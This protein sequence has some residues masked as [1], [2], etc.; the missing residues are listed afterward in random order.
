MAGNTDEFQLRTSSKNVHGLGLKS[1]SL[2]CFINL[3][4]K[5]TQK[6]GFFYWTSYSIIRE[7]VIM[8]SSFKIHLKI[9]D[10][11]IFSQ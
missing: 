6:G 7:H 9:K 5:L 8:L 2:S 3:K 1:H 10:S 11:F 4:D